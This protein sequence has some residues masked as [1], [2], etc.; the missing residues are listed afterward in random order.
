MGKVGILRV[1]SRADSF[2]VPC[3][4]VLLLIANTV[5][6]CPEVAKEKGIIV[7]TRGSEQ[8]FPLLCNRDT[9]LFRVTV[10]LF[11]KPTLVSFK[12]QN[13]YNDDCIAFKLFF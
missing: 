8:T 12:R 4:Q 11:F 13:I 2:N 5:S 3:T 6:L 7:Y 10:N 1:P 9:A